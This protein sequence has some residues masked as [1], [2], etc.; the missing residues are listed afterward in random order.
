MCVY[1]HIYIY[2]REKGGA[3]SKRLKLTKV[4]QEHTKGTKQK[5]QTKGAN[6]GKY[7]LPNNY[8]VLNQSTKSTKDRLSFHMMPIIIQKGKQKRGFLATD[9]RIPH[10]Q[11]PF[12]FFH[13]KL[14]RKDTMGQLT[15]LSTTFFL[16]KP[17]SS[18]ATSA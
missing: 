14:A 16:L 5:G 18:L 9:L 12:N 6:K 10:L 4:Q 3:K 7:H 11:M 17:H 8:L 15:K 13:T 1:I 2:K